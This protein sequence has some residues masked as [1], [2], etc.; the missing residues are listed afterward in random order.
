M[1]DGWFAA[2]MILLIFGIFIGGALLAN[3]VLL[4]E[5]CS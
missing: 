1:N 3:C 2:L 4:D 5:I